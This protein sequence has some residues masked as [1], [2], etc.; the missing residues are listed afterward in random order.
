MLTCAIEGHA[1]VSADGKIAAAD[2]SMPKDLM[3]AEDWRIFQGALDRADLV[4][5][6]R[7][8]HQRHPNPGRRR[9]VVTRS[10][11][12]LSPDPEDP[13][14]LFWNPGGLMI[15]AMLQELG[16]E[17]GTLAIT[18]GQGV[19]DLFLP[20]YTLFHLSEVH[21]FAL[22]DG[23]DTFSSGHPRAVLSAAGLV[24]KNLVRLDE[25]PLVTL[26]TWARSTG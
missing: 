25:H 1:I 18:G 12:R 9:L 23:I 19:F 21:H 16:L 2:G 5:L 3:H 20:H 13:R 6:G 15:E 8:G 26:T 22:P 7:K 14:A 24:P 10:I 17:T 4:V 11:E